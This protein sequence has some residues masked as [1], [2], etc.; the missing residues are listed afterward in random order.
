MWLYSLLPSEKP[1]IWSSP[2]V[3]DSNPFITTGKVWGICFQWWLEYTWENK[4][5]QLPVWALAGDVCIKKNYVVRGSGCSVCPSAGNLPATWSSIIGG[6]YSRRQMRD[7]GLQLWGELPKAAGF[8]GAPVTRAGFYYSHHLPWFSL[9]WTERKKQEPSW[10]FLKISWRNGP[11]KCPWRRMDQ[12][13]TWRVCFWGAQATVIFQADR[14]GKQAE[15]FVPVQ[16]EE[17]AGGL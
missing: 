11:S 9:K 4:T 3:S 1:S 17:T 10:Q 8:Q 15:S 6:R 14:H 12:R 5:K 13:S 2:Q 16:G 7:K